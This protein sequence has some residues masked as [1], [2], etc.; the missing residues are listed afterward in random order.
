MVETQLCKLRGTSDIYT[1]YRSPVFYDTYTNYRSQKK[2]EKKNCS[3]V[4]LRRDHGLLVRRY[5]GACT[6]MSYICST[7]VRYM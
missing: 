3:F 2:R 7:T 1:N 4:V 5:P 6:A